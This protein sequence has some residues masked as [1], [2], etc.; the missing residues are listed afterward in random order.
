M[1]IQKAPG[2]TTSNGAFHATIETAKKEELCIIFN[3]EEPLVASD[4]A[5]QMADIIVKHGDA[6]AAILGTK[7]RKPR[8]V[9]AKKRGRPAG[10]KNQP[11]TEPAQ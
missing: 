4:A 1:P 10:S 6:I 9:T 3:G 2:Y 7:A 8:T 5:Q 11:A